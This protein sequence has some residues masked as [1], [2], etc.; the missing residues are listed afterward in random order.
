MQMI[1]QYSVHQNNEYNDKF[2]CFFSTSFK[3]TYGKGYF[4]RY[5]T[6]IECRKCIPLDFGDHCRIKI[7][8]LHTFFTIFGT[9]KR[10]PSCLHNKDKDNNHFQVHNIRSLKNNVNFSIHSYY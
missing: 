8:H 2:N 5:L 9:I 7:P 4:V 6:G 1:I 3:I 10:Q